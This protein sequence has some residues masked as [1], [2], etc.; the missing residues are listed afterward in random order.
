VLFARAW[1][2]EPELLLLDEPFAGRRCSYAPHLLER[3]LALR[4]EDGGGDERSSPG[5]LARLCKP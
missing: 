5:R 1:V 3:V 2:R 4:R